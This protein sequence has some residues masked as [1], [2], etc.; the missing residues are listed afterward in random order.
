MLRALTFALAM[1][2]AATPSRANVLVLD[3]LSG[4][5]EFDEKSLTV[6][7]DLAE[8]EKS[9][10]APG[11]T[12]TWDCLY[13]LY[14]SL[15]LVKSDVAVVEALASLDTDMVNAADE[16]AVLNELA[17]RLK[18]FLGTFA[19]QR[20]AINGTMGQQ[21]CRAGVVAVKAQEILQLY[22][23]LGSVVQAINSKVRF[24]ARTPR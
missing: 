14:Q 10:L 24:K 19:L 22:T 23:K 2:A 17:D 20:K 9:A 8:A 6:L 11:S 21:G 1:L 4:F 13:N 18:T 7:Q 5:Y 16:Q 12:Q 3:D 15:E